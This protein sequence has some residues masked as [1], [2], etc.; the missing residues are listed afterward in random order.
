[1][2]FVKIFSVLLVAIAATFAFG[3]SAWSADGERTKVKVG[4]TGEIYQDIWEPAIKELAAEG[5][6]VEL[7]SFSDY[8]LPNAALDAGEIDLNTFQHYN[9]LNNEVKTKGYKI[10][11]IADTFLASMSVYSKKIKNL[12]E[13]KEGDKIA[14]P[15][16][17][18]NTGRALLVLQGAGIIKVDPGKGNTP[19]TTDVT[20]NPL[21]IEFVPVDAAQVPSLL[22][23]VAAGVVNGGYA[24]D[25]G[26][27]PSKDAI[28][29]DDLSFYK[30]KGYVNIVAARSADKDR[31]I[32][33][34]IVKAFHSDGVKRVLADKF[35]GS[36]LPVWED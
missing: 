21:K 32:F 31:E 20:S 14:I 2:K 27:N 16:D 35:K 26:L 28:F 36:L 17:V 1:M 30:D 18:I 13:L 25:F 6:D 34:R 7:I 12:S 33:K 29:Y 24:V 10:T 3:D 5:I 23:D 8:T 22:P 4:V 15:N 9:Y 19:E 11:A